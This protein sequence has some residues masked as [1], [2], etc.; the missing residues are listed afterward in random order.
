MVEKV[1]PVDEHVGRRIRLLR[2]LRKYSQE[3]LAKALGIT[4]QQVQKYERGTNRV[5]A[6]RLYDLAQILDVPVGF[7]FDGLEG[8]TTAHGIGLHEEQAGF[9]SGSKGGKGYTF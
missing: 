6:S 4:F 1:S 8:F 9:Q 3:K 5:G 7:F 2:G